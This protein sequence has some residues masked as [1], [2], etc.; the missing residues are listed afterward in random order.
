VIRVSNRTTA[1]GTTVV[2]ELPAIAS[3]QA[4]TTQSAAIY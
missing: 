4:F 1:S 2:V 3:V